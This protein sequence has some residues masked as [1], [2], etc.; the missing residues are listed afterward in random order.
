MEESGEELTIYLADDHALVAQGLA[1]LLGKLEQVQEIKLFANGKDLY[2]ACLNKRPDFVFLDLEMPVW[3]GTQTLLELKKTWPL[4]PVLILSML[5]E[6][7]VIEDCIEKGA[8]AYLNKDCSYEEICE[9]LKT[10]ANGELYYSREALKVLAGL[11]N[12]STT[13]LQLTEELSEREIEILTLICDGFSPKEI[14]E[15][16]FLS[17]RTVETHKNNIMQKFGVSSV[18]KLISLAIKNKIV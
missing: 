14:A 12:K 15:K 17:P 13:S 18:G 3:G 16:L 1:S 4:V 11:K 5:N 2:K 6:K 8:S 9:A 7:V 10:V